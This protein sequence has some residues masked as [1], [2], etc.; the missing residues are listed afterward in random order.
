MRSGSPAFNPLRGKNMKIE[1]RKIIIAIWMLVVF[2]F[3]GYAQSA[4]DWKDLETEYYKF[5][6][7][8]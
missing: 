4:D 8:A 3:T 7:P 5:A 6:V 1:S 2:S